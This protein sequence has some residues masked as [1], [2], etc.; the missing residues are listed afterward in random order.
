MDVPNPSKSW[1]AL[2]GTVPLQAR[3]HSLKHVQPFMQCCG[4]CDAECIFAHNFWQT[5]YIPFRNH[6]SFSVLNFSTV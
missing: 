3:T 5:Q 2:L 1:R 6:I 4:Q